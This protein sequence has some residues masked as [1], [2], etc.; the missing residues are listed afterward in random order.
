MYQRRG[1]VQS[2]HGQTSDYR[3]TEFYYHH[4][5]FHHHHHHHHH[6]NHRI[7]IVFCI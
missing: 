2:C 6:H 3:V 7:E 4:Y 5:H 1:Y